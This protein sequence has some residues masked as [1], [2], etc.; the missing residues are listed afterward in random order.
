MLLDSLKIGA[1]LE[2]MIQTEGWEYIETWIKN[3][4]KV[5]TAALKGRQF[6]DIAEVREL[7]AELKAYAML[8]SD[9]KHRIEQ[10]RKAMEKLN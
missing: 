6:T 5:V 1:Q 9:V 10:A 4:E 3:R 2:D 7:Q 8:I